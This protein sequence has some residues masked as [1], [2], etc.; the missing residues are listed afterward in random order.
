VHIAGLF[1]HPWA[2]TIPI[3][4]VSAWKNAMGSMDTCAAFI[5]GAHG[6]DEL[7]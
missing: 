7:S 5:D 3:S 6:N 1:G 4:R 2:A